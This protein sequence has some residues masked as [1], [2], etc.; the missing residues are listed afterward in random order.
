MRLHNIT[1][2]EANHPLNGNLCPITNRRVYI[3]DLWK[4]TRP[5]YRLRTGILEPGVVVSL[6][7]GHTRI[8]DTEAFFNIMHALRRSSQ[9]DAEKFVLVEDYTL[10]TGSDYEGRLTYIK[11]MIDEIHPLGIIFIARSTSW[12][13]SIKIGSVVYGAPFPI[14][15]SPSYRDAMRIASEILGRPLLGQQPVKAYDQIEKAN[16]SLSLE[17]LTPSLLYVKLSGCPSA[18]DLASIDDFYLGLPHHP[19]V[20]KT[21]RTIHDFSAMSPSA[22][23]VMVRIFSL[24]LSHQYNNSDTIAI[25]KGNA[26]RVALLI[27]CIGMVKLKNQRVAFFRD[28]DGAIDTMQP[29]VEIVPVFRE[30]L[31]TTALEMLE[32]IAWDKPG[33]DHLETVIDPYLKPLALMLGSI[34]QDV[35]YYMQQRQN[36]LDSL[37]ELNRRARQLSSEIEHA[38]NRSE[39]DRHKAE[40][41]SDKNLSL[42]KEI[43]TSQT[44][45]FLVLADYI[46]R[47]ARFTPG[48]TRKRA[49]LVAK[50][51]GYFGYNED[52]RTRMHN[53][54]LLM[55][56]G[57]L[58]IPEDEQNLE[59]HCILGGEVLGEIFTLIM[60]FASHIARYHHEK[61]DGSGFPEHLL[62]EQIPQEARLIT[63]ADYL[64]SY[65]LLQVEQLLHRESGKTF[66]PAMVAIILENIA[67]IKNMITECEETVVA[68]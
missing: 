31:E 30:N 65:P 57:Y 28:R 49:W 66:D 68:V 33:Y 51:A 23:P 17:I 40:L 12:K 35:D 46:D 3:D 10:H 32:S 37:E 4:V 41:L 60:Q 15:C 38:F 27:R 50:I 26:S 47:R 64:L 11:R 39:E 52:D 5:E 21:F 22:I 24:A 56:T 14:L 45:V 36:E 2:W 29:D 67:D 19:E 9:L 13:L 8:D 20:T 58:A 43:T 18:N 54:T 62:G 1:P 48:S 6:P 61:W 44:E 63:L 59:R 7:V 16:F 34:K 25:V 55:H 42:S 53:A